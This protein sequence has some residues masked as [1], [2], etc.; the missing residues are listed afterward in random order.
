M[1][2]DVKGQVRDYCS[3]TVGV[4]LNICDLVQTKISYNTTHLITNLEALLSIIGN[5]EISNSLCR[6]TNSWTS[7]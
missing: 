3:P 6:I 2:H 5:T 1:T 7:T 4:L